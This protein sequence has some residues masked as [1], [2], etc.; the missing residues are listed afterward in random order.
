MS[1]TPSPSDPLHRLIETALLAALDGGVA[2]DGDVAPEPWLHLAKLGQEYCFPRRFN[3]PMS[4]GSFF[5]YREIFYML[6][7]AMD[8]VPEGV[9]VE[10]WKEI[11]NYKFKEIKADEKPLVAIDEQCNLTFA[12]DPSLDL[13]KDDFDPVSFLE[14]VKSGAYDHL[15][16]ETVEKARVNAV[17]AL[18]SMETPF[19]GLVERFLDLASK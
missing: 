2:P 17:K 12:E 14:A 18:S 4:Y 5:K 19:S 16:Y 13:T 9:S 1:R 7:S 11:R 15:S 10:F 6:K 8:V 3:A